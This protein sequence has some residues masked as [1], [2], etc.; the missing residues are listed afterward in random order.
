M[1]PAAPML[2]SFMSLLAPNGSA[3]LLG[4]SQVSQVPGWRLAT[5]PSSLSE[6]NGTEE[7]SSAVALPLALQRGRN[8]MAA[9]EA[10]RDPGKRINGSK[11]NLG[12]GVPF[13]PCALI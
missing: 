12:D 2:P 6:P 3:L 11:I 7:L 9:V 8:A 4:P 13:P 10:E 5:R 1:I